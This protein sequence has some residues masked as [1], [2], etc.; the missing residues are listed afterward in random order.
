MSKNQIDIGLMHVALVGSR[1]PVLEFVG[2]FGAMGCW[3]SYDHYYRFLDTPRTR[4]IASAEFENFS[5]LA[6]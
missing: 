3:E 5:M 6:F 1:S 2:S 4:E